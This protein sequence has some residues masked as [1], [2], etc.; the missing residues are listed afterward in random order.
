M[1][2]ERARSMASVEPEILT[3]RE[4]VKAVLRP[5]GKALEALL[6]KLHGQSAKAQRE[7]RRNQGVA[8]EKLKERL[9]GKVFETDETG[10]VV[11]AVVTTRELIG[12]VEAESNAIKVEAMAQRSYDV[13]R[14]TNGVAGGTGVGT[15]EEYL[16][17]L[18]GEEA[19]EQGQ[20]GEGRDAAE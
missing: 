8:R 11:V 12:W 10:A 15:I 2:E 7:A 6:V 13:H 4:A 18:E 17:K 3:A 19:A 16:T 1:S 14:V 9:E 20:L 5:N